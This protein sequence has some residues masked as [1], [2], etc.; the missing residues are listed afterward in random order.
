MSHVLLPIFAVILLG[1]GLRRW[2]FPGDAFWPLADRFNYY[3]CFPAL[4]FLRIAVTDFTALP[5][6]GMVLACAG[7][8]LLIAFG[9]QLPI[10]QLQFDAPAFTSVFQG[11]IR[12]NTYVGLAVA[13]ALFGSNG[14]ALLAVAIAAVIPLVNLFSVSVLTRRLASGRRS[15]WQVMLGILRNPLILA[16]LLGIAL[17]VLALPLPVLVQRPLE[18]LGQAALPLGL[19]TVGAGLQ[20]RG[21]GRAIDAL[22]LAA[23]LKLVILPLVTLVLGLALGVQGTALAIAVLFNAMPA[24]VSSYALASQLGGDTRLMAAIIT[25]QTLLAMISLPIFLLMLD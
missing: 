21:L 11:S 15:L 14:L 22:A 3:L 2:S 17:N 8:V 16:C 19:L 18:V 9:L 4:L 20:L 5:V 10:R 12:P 13:A 25:S 23:G 24:S 6:T 7:A 1:Y